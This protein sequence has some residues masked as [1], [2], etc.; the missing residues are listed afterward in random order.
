MSVIGTRPAYHAR[1]IDDQREENAALRAGR[2]SRKDGGRAA[3]TG[4]RIVLP[5]VELCE[6]GPLARDPLEQP[7]LLGALGVHPSRHPVKRQLRVRSVGHSTHSVLA[8]GARH[9]A[10]VPNDHQRSSDG[11]KNSSGRRPKRFERTS[12]TVPAVTSLCR[13]AA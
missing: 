5:L 13:I 10:R 12:V 3:D 9:D 6:G 8:S 4:P 1:S 11:C 2:S 7:S